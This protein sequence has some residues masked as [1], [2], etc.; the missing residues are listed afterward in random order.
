MP[1]IINDRRLFLINLLKAGCGMLLSSIPFSLRAEWPARLF[2]SQSFEQA[3]NQLNLNQTPRYSDRLE[4]QLPENAEDG[5]SVP[6]Q[7]QTDIANVSN[8]RILV[9]KNPTP[10]ILQWQLQAGVIPFLSCRIKM[11]ESCYVW[12][13]AEADGVFWYNKR[14][15][16]VMK[17]GC[18]TG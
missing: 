17:G 4:I 1:V 15:V 18:G 14:W 16:N 7:F 12:L 11:A 9:E 13:I 3:L 6:M 10:L 5:A 2:A 8:F